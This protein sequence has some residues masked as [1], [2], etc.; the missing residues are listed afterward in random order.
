MLNA[1]MVR[2][3]F[4]IFWVMAGLALGCGSDDSTVEEGAS[5][6][7]PS[8]TQA[9]P[10]ATTNANSVE[11]LP[12]TFLVNGILHNNATITAGQAIGEN[13]NAGRWINFKENGTYEYGLYDEK[14]YDGNWFYDG[15]TTLL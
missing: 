8:E 4:L 10:S 5:D 12:W 2:S 1:V 9:A 11:E 7:T 3:K 13:P 6:T 15:K 14:S